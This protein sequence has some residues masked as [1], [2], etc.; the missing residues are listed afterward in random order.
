VGAR[1]GRLQPG[2]RHGF[3]FLGL[4]TFGPLA[5]ADAFKNPVLDQAVEPV[6]EDV[7]AMPSLSW[8]SSKRRSP[9]KASRT[10]STVQRSPTTSSVRGDKGFV[11]AAVVDPFGNVLGIMYNP[12]HVEILRSRGPA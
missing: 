3:D 10:I 4:E 7:A 5:A 6:G 2:S 1:S 12:H 9:R 8:N 11:T